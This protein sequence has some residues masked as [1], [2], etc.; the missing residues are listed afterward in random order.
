MSIRACPK[1]N[2]GDLMTACTRR[3]AASDWPRGSRVA[4]GAEP[5]SIL[6]SIINR[7][8]T[9]GT[10]ELLRDLPPFG[11]TGS[12]WPGRKPGAAGSSPAA[13]ASTPRPCGGRAG[14]APGTREPRVSGQRSS[15]TSRRPC[16]HSQS[17]RLVL[18]APDSPMIRQVPAGPTTAPAWRIQC[19]RS[20]RIASLTRR[21][22]RCELKGAPPPVSLQRSAASVGEEEGAALGAAR[23]GGAEAEVDRRRGRPAVRRGNPG[24]G[25]RGPA[26]ARRE[27][28]GSGGERRG[29]VQPRSTAPSAPLQEVPADEIPQAFDE[30]AP[31]MGASGK[32]W[33]IS[34]NIRV[35]SVC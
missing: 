3:C 21:Y 11:E 25:R 9:A 14:R 5:R 32:I 4:P 27:P 13:A 6:R 18:P 20:R 22:S 16:A 29:S 10:G 35:E 33:P 17:V 26:A 19:S 2:D 34:C 8:V 7:W 30:V 15:V 28:R 23:V 24:A 1:S 31:S 12:S